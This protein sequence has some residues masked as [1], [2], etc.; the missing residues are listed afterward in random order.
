MVAMAML[1]LLALAGS[2]TASAAPQARQAVAA[3]CDSLAARIAGL[4]ALHDAVASAVATLEQQIATGG[5]RARQ[6]ALAQRLLDRLEDQLG[7]F[8]ARLARL[9]ERQTE[10]CGGGGGDPGG[11][12]DEGGF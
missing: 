8:D 4:Q 7:R 12:G 3:P 1:A 5:L 6:L 10:R 2:V 11:G 9:L